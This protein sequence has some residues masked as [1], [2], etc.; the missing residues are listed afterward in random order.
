MKF[1]ILL[2]LGRPDAPLLILIRVHSWLKKSPI[3]NRSYEIH[4]PPLPVPLNQ[5]HPNC[6][7]F[8]NRGGP[9][10]PYNYLGNNFRRK[11][12]PSRV[13]AADTRIGESFCPTL[14]RP[15]FPEN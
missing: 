12:L 4:L 3:V 14:G 8:W 7:R 15:V 6:D 1:F 13:R 11:T 2:T 10:L 5:R 9:A